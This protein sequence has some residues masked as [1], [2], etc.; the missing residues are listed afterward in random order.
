MKIFLM[1]EAIFFVGER[2]VEIYSAPTT[3]RASPICLIEQSLIKSR[4]LLRVS[5]GTRI[6]FSSSVTG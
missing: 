4:A 5:N 6:P 1:S 2:N 3:P